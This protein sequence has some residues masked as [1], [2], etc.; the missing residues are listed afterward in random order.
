MACVPSRLQTPPKPHPIAVEQMSLYS[1]WYQE[2][3]KKTQFH[4][5]ISMLLRSRIQSIIWNCQ[6]IIIT[7]ITIIIIIIIADNDCDDVTVTF[8]IMVVLYC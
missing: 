5:A 3:V 6:N 4:F 1:R 8:T 7:I 2:P